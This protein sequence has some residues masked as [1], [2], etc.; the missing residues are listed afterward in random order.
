MRVDTRDRWGQPAEEL[1]QALSDLRERP[2]TVYL[3]LTAANEIKAHFR[4]LRILFE[5]ATSRLIRMGEYP[6]DRASIIFLMEEFPV[7]GYLETMEHAA[8]FMPSYGI[9]LHLVAQSIIQLQTN[10]PRTWQSFFNGAGVAQFFAN[11]G[12]CDAGIRL[13]AAG[14]ADLRAAQVVILGQ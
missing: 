6:R 10:Y 9:K 14:Q 5:Q 1:K 12:R 4:W 3:V 13:E 11:A 2:T 8:A 7:L